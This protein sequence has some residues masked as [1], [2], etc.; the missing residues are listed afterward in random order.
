MANRRVIYARVPD[1]VPAEADFRVEDAAS[2]EA[3]P[4]QLHVRNLWLS[5]APYQRL[6][7]S[8]RYPFTPGFGVGQLMP[9]ETVSQVIASNDPGF[10][11]G[12][13]VLCRGGWQAEAVVP[14]GSAERLPDGGA[15]PRRYLDVLGVNGLTA[16]AGL[17]DTGRPRP[18]DTVLVSAA[19]GSVGGLVGQ[20]A[21]IAGCR[22][23]G[24]AGGPEKCGL[25]VGTLGLDACV[26][27]KAPDFADRLRAACPDGVDVYFDNVGGPVLDAAIPLLT[28]GGRIV[29]C[30]SASQYNAATPHPPPP[31]SLFVG[32]RA[33]VR[34]FVV[35]D[36]MARIGD[37]RRRL[38]RWLADGRLTALEDVAEGLD[39]APALFRRL[40]LGQ[41]VGKTLIRL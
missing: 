34:G 4:G 28:T 21:R 15:E 8:G 9:G 24:I 36:H 12:D 35:Y 41:T 31:L 20:I 6:A 3:G 32:K 39:A 16:F 30:G 13:L 26:D 38:S 29:L 10:S 37:V 23:V 40:M 19:A 27:Y 33:E 1:G 18:G 14:A 25:A 7:M 2:P 17:V 22:A 5:L 11:P